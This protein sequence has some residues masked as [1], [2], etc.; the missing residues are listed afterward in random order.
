M[1][2]L[3]MLH[4]HNRWLIALFGISSVI[5]IVINLIQSSEF[6]SRTGITI[7]IYAYVL[8]FQFLGGLILFFPKAS[9]LNWDMSAL[10]IQLEH[11]TTMILAIAIAHSTAAWK[12]AEPRK[13]L[14]NSLIAVCISLLL[15]VAGVARIGGMQLWMGN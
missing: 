11:A 9:A 5:T 3:Q 8:A 10:R 15:V 6:N 14:R 4:G 1:E 2:F 7:K 12:S 13:R